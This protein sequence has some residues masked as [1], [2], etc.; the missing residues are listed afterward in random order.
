MLVISHR[1][2][3]I[4]DADVIYVLEQGRVVESGTWNVLATQAHG[5]FRA[6]CRAQGIGI[7]SNVPGELLRSADQVSWN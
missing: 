1:L 7:D 4:R 5:R 2:S 3:T 6:L